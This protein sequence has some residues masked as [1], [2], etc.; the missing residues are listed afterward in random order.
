MRAI[1]RKRKRQ[2]H[3]IKATTELRDGEKTVWLNRNM[4]RLEVWCVK[5][6]FFLRF[7]I[8]SFIFIDWSSHGCCGY[9]SN[10]QQGSKKPHYETN[11]WLACR[12]KDVWVGWLR[13]IRAW[14]LLDVTKMIIRFFILFGLFVILY[15]KMRAQQLHLVRWVWLW[16]NDHNLLDS[17]ENI[18][19]GFINYLRTMKYSI[20]KG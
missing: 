15:R 20:I 5:S 14:M 16:S 7:L 4:I 19:K 3:H 10:V 18:I 12:I 11:T 6:H 13:V 1:R 8:F 17:I 9:K 2:K